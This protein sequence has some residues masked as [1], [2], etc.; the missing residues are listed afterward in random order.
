MGTESPVLTKDTTCFMASRAG[1]SA[2]TGVDGASSDSVVPGRPATDPR[3]KDFWRCQD[4]CRARTVII[5]PQGAGAGSAEASGW[6]FQRCNGG[7]GGRG[8][9]RSRMNKYEQ[10]GLDKL[11]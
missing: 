7:C 4:C 8:G 2:F 5:S 1:L 10:V 6:D 11:V 3:P 9:G